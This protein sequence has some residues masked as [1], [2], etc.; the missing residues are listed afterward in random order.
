MNMEDGVPYRSPLGFYKEFAVDAMMLVVKADTGELYVEMP[1]HIRN[2]LE[3]VVGSRLKGVVVAV[4]RRG[5]SLVEVN[6][7]F[8]WEIDGYWHELHLP[9][10]FVKKYKIAAGDSIMIVLRKVVNYGIERPT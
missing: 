4:R 9:S 10:A 8:D 2:R 1:S 6:E 5:K 3:L 7:E